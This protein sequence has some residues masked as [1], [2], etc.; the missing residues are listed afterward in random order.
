MDYRTAKCMN[1]I[2]ES[3]VYIMRKIRQVNC[4]RLNSGSGGSVEL[5]ISL[6][7][8]QVYHGYINDTS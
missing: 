5:S 4:Q 6:A 2:N 1:K 7:R 3:G 8:V